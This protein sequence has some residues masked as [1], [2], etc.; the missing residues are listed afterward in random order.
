MMRPPLLA[1]LSLA[2][3]L[4]ASPAAAQDPVEFGRL[5]TD[6]KQLAEQVRRLEKILLTLEERERAEGEES[7]AQLLAKAREKLIDG[8]QERPLAS[9]LEEVAMDLS[10]LRAGAALERQAELILFLEE[11]LDFLLETERREQV[12]NLMQAAREREAA[13]RDLAQRQA[14]LRARTEALQER[15]AETGEID[16]AARQQLAREQAELNEEIRAAAESEGSNAGQDEVERAADEGERAESELNGETQAERERREAQEGERGDSAEAPESGQPGEQAESQP[17]EEGERQPGEEGERQPGEEGERR[18]GEESSEAQ[19]GEQPENQPGKQSERQPGEQ[20]ERQSGEQ[21]ERQPGEQNE[22]QPGEQQDQQQ[23]SRNT[24][25]QPQSPQQR[26]EQL[27]RAEDAQ[28][29]AEEELERAADEAAEEAERLEGVDELET[30]I[31]VLEKSEELLARHERVMDGLGGLVGSLEGA[32]RVPRSARVDLRTWSTEE[33]A[34]A[35]EADALLF[36]IREAGA[37]TFPFLLRGLVDDHQLLAKRVGPPRYRADAPAVEM[38]VRIQRDWTRLIDAIRT[39]AERLRKKLNEP[40][41][42]EQQMDPGQ[43]E[44]EQQEPPN[45]PSPLV[46]VA[47]EIQL[48]KQLQADLL[49]RME[50]LQRRREL[51][52]EAGVELDEDDLAE[53]EAVVERQKRLRTLFENILERLQPSEETGEEI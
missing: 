27:E 46:S 49:E 32:S 20:S 53:L 31:N 38:G 22:R 40:E 37:D 15:E 34:I 5:S 24:P 7:R 41:G 11:L 6:Q 1:L 18:P 39:E 13:L 21:S 25:R 30:L 12:Q 16:E 50:S 10:E 14:E 19:P 26:Q 4:F 52:A 28:R 43:Q 9:V 17:G 45:E 47:A 51:L 29:R 33:R 3:V 23:Q 42:G 2:P 35:E 48:L 8:A 36:E 44:G